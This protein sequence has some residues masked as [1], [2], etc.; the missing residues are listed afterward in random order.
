MTWRRE[1]NYYVRHCRACG[2]SGREYLRQRHGAG[3]ADYPCC[4]GTDHTEIV[5]HP[6]N[7]IVD[8]LGQ[9]LERCDKCGSVWLVFFEATGDSM[10]VPSPV[11]IGNMI[12][13][14]DWQPPEKH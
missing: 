8:H 9:R 11:L 13:E 10:D 4:P 6:S 2:G 5:E 3:Y 7:S 14:D 1:G 12:P